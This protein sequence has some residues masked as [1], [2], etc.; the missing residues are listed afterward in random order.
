MRKLHRIDLLILD[1]LALH[2]VDATDTSDFYELI[3]ERHRQASTIITSTREPPEMRTMMADSLLTQSALNR[4]Q[5]TAFELIIEDPRYQQRQK[6]TLANLT[7][8]QHNNN[9]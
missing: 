7:T 8:T 9:H 2:P 4:L 1:D 3:V 5:S 6:P